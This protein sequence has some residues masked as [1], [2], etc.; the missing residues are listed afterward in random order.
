MSALTI[1]GLLSA[2]Q[3]RRLFEAT[4]AEER[5]F[6][7]ASTEGRDGYRSAAVL[8]TIV[9]EAF[10]VV[11]RVAALAPEAARHFRLRLPRWPRIEH[12]ITAYRDG[13]RYQVHRDDDGVDPAGRAL[14]YVY[15]F[16]ESPCR[17]R[18]GELV[19]HHGEREEVISPRNN[20]L[21]MF[22][23]A[24]PHEVRV[25]SAPDGVRA[26]R[27]TVNGWLWRTGLDGPLE[28]SSISKASTRA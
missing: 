12:Q 28:S 24:V 9:D 23:S 4:V 14:T 22:P 17:Y 27:Y 6:V 16:N 25:V 15:Y 8:Y 13:D 18:G 26:R 11:D 5:W 1:D 7:E 3:N 20:R 19:L 10:W 21:I 2:A